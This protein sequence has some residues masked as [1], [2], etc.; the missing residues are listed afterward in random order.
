MAL[1]LPNNTSKNQMNSFLFSVQ[2]SFAAFAGGYDT[3][4]STLSCV[5]AHR[6][7]DSRGDC[8]KP[9]V[10]KPAALFKCN[11]LRASSSKSESTGAFS[12]FVGVG[13]VELFLTFYADNSI[14]IR[15]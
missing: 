13:K 12:L 4:R 8:L 10:D 11:S 9:F 14:N 2:S 15:N 5:A 1:L 6:I 7:V 3:P